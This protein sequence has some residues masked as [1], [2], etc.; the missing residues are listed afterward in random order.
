MTGVTRVGDLNT[1]HDSCPAVAL[2]Q[3]SNSVFFNGKGV[4]RV[5]DPYV[6]HGCSSH[7]SHVGHISSGSPSVFAD[8][9]AVGRIGDNV[10]CNSANKI[11]EGSTNIIADEG[12]AG[13]AEPI[14][15]SM[16]ASLLKAKNFYTTTVV[17]Q[18]D[19][20][21]VI[22][23]EPTSEI[24]K[25][26]MSLPGIAKNMAKLQNNEQDRQG[27]NYLALMFER[28]LG[29]P[30]RDGGKEGYSNNYF[31]I[32]LDWVLSYLRVQEAVEDLRR[33]G[34][35]YKSEQI[36]ADKL[37]NKFNG[38]IVVSRD[39]DYSDNYSDWDDQYINHVSI[40]GC[41]Y[42]DLLGVTGLTAAMGAFT[43]RLL[44]K[45][46]VEPLENGLIKV[47]VT[48]I[49]VYIEDRFQFADNYPL[50]F[51]SYKKLLFSLNPINYF[52]PDYVFLNNDFF[53][54]FRITYNK[55]E[56][57]LIRSERCKKVDYFVPKT[58]YLNSDWI[59]VL[60]E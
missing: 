50:F 10:D 42:S 45:G 30:A 3:G 20:E 41:W 16:A 56:D 25:T 36:L 23:Y 55:G 46:T 48:E 5:G 6:A 7:P 58:F 13:I 37:K 35:N 4:G 26:I 8:G 59:V 57:F 12:A 29:N 51:W 38:N 54:N 11:A 47:Q 18:I 60:D 19:G 52:S 31:L 15:F 40:P 2:A 1:G 17:D 33:H 28:W 21:D 9:F 53:R 27:W 44:P 14:L 43:V 49:A 24:D 39:F 34:L 32:D 22:T